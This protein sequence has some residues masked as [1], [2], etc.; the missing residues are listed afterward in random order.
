M[1][2][3]S[4]NTATI[5]VNVLAGHNIRHSGS[6]RISTLMPTANFSADFQEPST[7][8]ATLSSKGGDSHRTAGPL[9]TLAQALTT[10]PAT[11]GSAST[12]SPKMSGTE[13]AK[14]TKLKAS[15]AKTTER[16]KA[17]KLPPS[18]KSPKEVTTTQATTTR[19]MTTQRTT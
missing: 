12:K 16:P 13:D 15:K 6:R 4:N 18:T 2:L 3:T 14:P 19:P 10:K 7:T 11:T 9:S 17:K 1:K 5:A 8:S